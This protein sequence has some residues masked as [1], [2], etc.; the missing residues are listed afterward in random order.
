MRR[1]SLRPPA[2]GRTHSRYS[3]P[4]TRTVS[5]A[6]ATPA[7]RLMVR[8]GRSAVPSA[9]SAPEVATWSTEPMRSSPSAW[10]WLLAEPGR[11]TAQQLA[12][13]DGV[14]QDD[15]DRREGDR[16]GDGR[17]VDAELAL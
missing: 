1:A 10:R 8:N 16:C 14:H 9:S 12:A 2:R 5:P 11:Q 3:P 17:H 15:R 4:C 7:A 13:A 6:R